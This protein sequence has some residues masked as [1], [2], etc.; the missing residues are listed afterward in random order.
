[1]ILYQTYPVV[2]Q[3]QLTRYHI[4]QVSLITQPLVYDLQSTSQLGFSLI[5]APEHSSSV[6]FFPALDYF[7]LHSNLTMVDLNMSEGPQA[8]TGPVPVVTTDYINDLTSLV[9]AIKNFTRNSKFLREQ[10]EG[11]K[12]N[13]PTSDDRYP[14]SMNLNQKYDVIRHRAA[15]DKWNSEPQR[16]L[17][18]ITF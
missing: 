18:I 14:S 7:S 17:H 10:M 1:M 3:Y 11:R 4:I 6:E 12:L 2:Y 9:N 8:S 15:S 16:G 13:L 5:A